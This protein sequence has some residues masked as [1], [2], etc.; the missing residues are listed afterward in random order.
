MPDRPGRPTS[1]RLDVASDARPRRA[2]SAPRPSRSG[3]RSWRR[4]AS[5]TTQ[6][7]PLVAPSR[8]TTVCTTPAIAITAGPDP[9]DRQVGHRDQVGQHEEGGRQRIRPQESSAIRRFVTDHRP[10]EGSAEDGGCEREEPADRGSCGERSAEEAGHGLLRAAGDERR[11][12][13]RDHGPCCDEDQ[14]PDQGD[15]RVD[16]GVVRESSG[17][18]PEIPVRDEDLAE[19]QQ[20]RRADRRARLP[21][22]CGPLRRSCDAGRSGEGA[23][24]RER[25]ATTI[26]ADIAPS[27]AD[28]AGAGHR[29]G[30]SPRR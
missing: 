28:H 8:R 10:D 26:D 15:C 19:Q 4:P 30:R 23:R 22:R 11:E 16:A 14:P 13:D 21:G 9:P 1:L 24:R 29:G 18:H 3:A 6:S 20:D 7:V 12:D 2:P 17:N 25:P 5:W 27:A